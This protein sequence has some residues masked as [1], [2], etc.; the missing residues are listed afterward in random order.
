MY[1]ASINSYLVPSPS[2]VK[3]L[4]TLIWILKGQASTS[5]RH[6]KKRNRQIITIFP[7]IRK[8]VQ[9]SNNPPYHFDGQRGQ[10]WTKSTCWIQL[11]F[12]DTPIAC[13]T[14]KWRKCNTVTIRSA[15]AL[16]KSPHVKTSTRDRHD[17]GGGG[18][19]IRIDTCISQERMEEPIFLC[20]LTKT[21][22]Q[23]SFN[24]VTELRV[25]AT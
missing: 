6:I 3:H 18:Y 8:D 14:R 4:I 15:H 19:K 10:S 2:R 24:Y 5:V 12:P 17:G 13:W 25:W 9:P 7:R 11:T 21:G 20:L 22:D 16:G 23:P 1:H